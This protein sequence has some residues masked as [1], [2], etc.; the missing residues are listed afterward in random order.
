M[1]IDTLTG[2]EGVSTSVVSKTEEDQG[3]APA[4]VNALTDMIYSVMGAD[5]KQK[6]STF[7]IFLVNKVLFFKF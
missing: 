6:P 3:L 7:M 2:L 4:L 1:E 5:K